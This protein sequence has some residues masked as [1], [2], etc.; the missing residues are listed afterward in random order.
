[1][2]YPE[3]QG[4]LLF[5]STRPR[6]ARRDLE[7]YVRLPSKF[8]S[9]RPR[10]ARRGYRFRWGCGETFQSTRPRGA[11]LYHNVLLWIH[12]EVSIHAPARGA[13]AIIDALSAERTVS[14]HAPARGATIVTPTTLRNEVSF[15]PRAR[16][17]RDDAYEARRQRS[18]VSIHAPAR[19][20]TN[21]IA[22]LRALAIVSIHAPA[23]GATS[24]PSC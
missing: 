4:G 21:E 18:S 3:R 17:G 9:T 11:R 2:Q 7:S 22:K 1:M 8:Q 14:I 24:T 20:A 19:G 13:T 15:N 23:R 16:E 5:Q 12:H 10:G 6:G